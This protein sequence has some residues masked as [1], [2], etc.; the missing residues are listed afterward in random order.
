MR[1]PQTLGPIQ[2]AEMSRWGCYYK[3]LLTVRGIIYLLNGVVPFTYIQFSF[4]Y[5]K[6]W[7]V[8]ITR[9]FSV[10]S[11]LGVMVAR[12]LRPEP[13]AIT[14][15]VGSQDGEP[16]FQSPKERE[17]WQLYRRMLEKGVSVSYDTVLR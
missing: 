15:P 5:Q 9:S 7:I 3:S 8:Y 6:Y 13:K 11:G 12:I 17:C 10:S 14:D 4:R 1:G 16:E 2:R